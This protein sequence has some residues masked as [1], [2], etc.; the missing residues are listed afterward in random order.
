MYKATNV[1]IISASMISHYSIAVIKMNDFR[2]FLS[3]NRANSVSCIPAVASYM[4][5]CQGTWSWLKRFSDKRSLNAN[6]HSWELIINWW[7]VMISLAVI[8][9][10]V[11]L[12]SKATGL[13]QPCAGCVSTRH[14]SPR[15]TQS[16]SDF[17]TETTSI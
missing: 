14:Q 17:P 1:S 16:G 12:S 3:E 11:Q 15:V 10:A 4:S 5:P 2:E 6:S 9:S 13:G 8:L 7:V